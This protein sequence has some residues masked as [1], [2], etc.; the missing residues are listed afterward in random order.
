[1]QALK[2]ASAATQGLI[3]IR[4]ADTTHL[5]SNRKL[6]IL[7]CAMLTSVLREELDGAVCLVIE[8][9]RKLKNNEKQILGWHHLH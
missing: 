5:D 8:K 9:K 6:K 4:L 2:L 7:G 1:M 3:D